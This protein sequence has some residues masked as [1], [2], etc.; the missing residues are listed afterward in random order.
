MAAYGEDSSRSALTFIPPFEMAQ[1]MAGS[2]RI[3]TRRTSDTGDGFPTRQISDMDK[4]VVERGI[5][6]GNAENELS[7]SDLRTE[8]DGGFFPGDLLLG[9]L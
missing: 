2:M 8:R 4:G 1:M 3:A 6:V 7:L 5:D 9:R